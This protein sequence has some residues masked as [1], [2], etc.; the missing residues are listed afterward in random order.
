MKF[1]WVL[2]LIVAPLVSY[3]DD[4]DVEMTVAPTSSYLL[5]GSASNCLDFS[6]Y[7]GTLAKATD[8]LPVLATSVP[9]LR[10]SFPAFS[11]A[12]N[13]KLDLSVTIMRITI[14]SDQLVGGIYTYDL[15]GEELEA[16]IGGSLAANPLKAGKMTSNDPARDCDPA[17]G[18]NVLTGEA[19]KAQAETFSPNYAACGLDVG[20]VSLMDGAKAF[21]APMTIELFGFTTDNAG[22]FNPSYS[23]VST[24][25][26][27]TGAQ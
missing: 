1:L 4:G 19:C 18:K 20:G 9:S 22:S 26:E 27:Y 5:P 23:A 7:K 14:Q 6:T 3:A 25:V 21:K 2:L 10:V 16:L 12:W 24:S 17:T 15:Y 11:L 8:K 13:G